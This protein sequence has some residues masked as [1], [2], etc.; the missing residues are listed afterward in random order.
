MQRMKTIQ[1]LFVIIFVSAILFSCQ[2]Q[3]NEKPLSIAISKERVN[4]NR[5]E[6]WLEAATGR[7]INAINLFALTNRQILDTLAFCD[8]LLLSGGVDVHPRLYGKEFDTVRCG[9]I[10]TRRDSFEIAVYRKAKEMK[11][12]VLG[13]CRGLQFINVAE[14]GTLF[15]DLPQDLQTGDLHRVGIEDW[16]YHDVAFTNSNLLSDL[17]NESR[18]QVA[19]NHHQGIE[20]LA[21][22]LKIIAISSDG[23]AEAISRENEDAAPFML[24]VQWHPEWKYQDDPLSK[25]IAIKFIDAATVYSKRK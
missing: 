7:Q 5:Y 16:T 3:V 25:L 12:P 22:G 15:V 4:A 2:Q 21:S 8:A 9:A 20:R 23:L 18:Y 1:N 6:S 13:I 11:M 24:A 10:D 17:L 14:G 19:S